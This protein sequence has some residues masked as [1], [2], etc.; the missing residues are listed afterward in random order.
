MIEQR[1]R[2]GAERGRTWSGWR[3]G[4]LAEA[5][6][7]RRDAAKLFREGRHLLPP[8]QMV[9]AGAVQ[10]QHGG[11][12]PS[13]VL[14]VETEVVLDHE[15]HRAVLLVLSSRQR[16]ST[17]PARRRHAERTGGRRA[18]RRPSGGTRRA[19]RR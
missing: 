5:A 7:I 15:W 8:A 11:A 14:V 16:H 18:S 12:W 17:A 2:I 4:R 1:E 9:P 6:L 3:V 13:G 19:R 10:E